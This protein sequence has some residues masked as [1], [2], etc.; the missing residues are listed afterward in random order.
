MT[1]PYYDALDDF[2]NNPEWWERVRHRYL[3]KETP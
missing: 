2:A 3:D 1:A